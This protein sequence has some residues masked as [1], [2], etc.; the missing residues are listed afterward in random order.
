MSVTRASKD[1]AS[2]ALFFP[3]TLSIPTTQAMLPLTSTAATD[4][5]C[6]VNSEYR[7]GTVSAIQLVTAFSQSASTALL[8]GRRWSRTA[9]WPKNGFRNPNGGLSLGQ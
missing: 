2:P 3:L 5:I 6:D 9:C 1:R 8:P 7:L 4:V